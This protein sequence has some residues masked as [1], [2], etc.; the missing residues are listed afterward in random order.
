MI[1]D[2]LF[3]DNKKETIFQ[4]W[5]FSIFLLMLFGWEPVCLYLVFRAV[6]YGTMAELAKTCCL[7]GASLLFFGGVQYVNQT[8]ADRN[9]W[10]IITSV[11]EQLLRMYYS[12]DY[13]Q[14]HKRFTYGELYDRI[15]YSGIG[16]LDYAVHFLSIGIFTLLSGAFGA[17]FFQ[18]FPAILI[19][20][21]LAAVLEI[22]AAGMASKKIG[23]LEQ[24][25][26][27]C[28]SERTE[29]GT[30][31]VEDMVFLQMHDIEEQALEQYCASLDR[32]RRKEAGGELVKEAVI[33][34]HSL[35]QRLLQALTQKE[36]SAGILA[37]AKFPAYTAAL[38]KYT[39]ALKE[40]LTRI[41]DIKKKKAMIRRIEALI[42]PTDADRETE[43]G[44]NVEMPEESRDAIWAEHMRVCLEGK[45]I[46][47][48]VCLQVKKGEKIAVVGAN[49]SG[50]S[51]LLKV[52][53]G[54][55]PLN[56]G[57]CY[58]NG[59]RA[60]CQTQ[61][62]R[63][64][65][66]YVPAAPFLFDG[67]VMENISMG[68]VEENPQWKDQTVRLCAGFLECDI[69][70]L[71][72]GQQQC[73]NACRGMVRSGGILFADEPTS[74]MD[75]ERA[76]KMMRQLIQSCET[77]IIITHDVQLLPLFDRVVIMRNGEVEE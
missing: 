20:A 18:W 60:G 40:V 66:S 42:L 30:L 44:E 19:V 6:E 15:F 13:S 2:F 4:F 14:I 46:L 65:I 12:L 70:T 75:G 68:E 53:L 54:L 45:E 10:K 64:Q 73:V 69:Q 22:A 51:T 52:M 1:R 29:R 24:E 27:V 9:S 11:R 34:T 16:I 41:L 47:K 3:R 62:D 21:V 76:Q 74:Q 48:D 38:E 25:I 33:R 67:S 5:V 63:K 36:L 35:F 32:V 7:M 37:L 49:G 8:Y 77:C 39:A 58:V 57:V 43:S 72:G 56:S 31:L 26:R 28:E 61:S 59:K 17:V 55:I 23:I 50:K 71:S